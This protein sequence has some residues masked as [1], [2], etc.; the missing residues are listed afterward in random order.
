MMRNTMDLKDILGLSVLGA[1]VTTVGS[2]IAA[3][4]KD[5]VFARSV[6]KWKARQQ[7]RQ[8]YLKIRDPLLLA[9]T[10]LV[11]RIGEITFKSPVNFL[12]AKLLQAT[13]LRM[14]TNSADDEYFQ[15]YKFLSSVYRLC[16]WLGWVELYRQEVAFLDSGQ[17]KTNA[18]FEHRI[19]AM[20]SSLADGQLNQAKD[21]HDWTDSLIFREEQRAIG[22]CMLDPARRRVVG[23]GSFY[24]SFNVSGS[25]PQNHWILVAT[26]FLTDLRS[27]PREAA[28]DFR[29]AR[30]LLLLQHGVALVACLNKERV[31]PRLR[32]LR[33]QAEQEL[34]HMP[35]RE[36]PLLAR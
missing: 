34:L 7:L 10:E 4:L 35:V 5:V 2:L 25:C 15:R 3:W 21:R 11:S 18:D 23:Y 8:V 22:E 13:P 16:A 32:K 20:R 33:K 24:E 29:R 1:L 30:C 28:R 31:T 6:E 26:N 36:L 14:T 17:Q 19:E 12:E 27:L 9:T